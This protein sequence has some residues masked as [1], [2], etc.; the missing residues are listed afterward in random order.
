MARSWLGGGFFAL[1]LVPMPSREGDH[2]IAL[3]RRE[4]QLLRHEVQVVEKR[5]KL[6]GFVDVGEQ[7]SHG[8][9]ELRWFLFFVHTRQSLGRLDRQISA[10]FLLYLVTHAL[11]AG[12]EI[13]IILHG[14]SNFDSDAVAEIDVDCHGAFFATYGLY[15][16]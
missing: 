15:C 12:D 4:S 7:R 14:S 10:V 13:V 2:D 3:A 9:A 5:Q 11:K 8:G 16:E 6:W 1:E